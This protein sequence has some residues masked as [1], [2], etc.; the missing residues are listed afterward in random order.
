MKK[1]ALFLT[2]IILLLACRP[3]PIISVTP[4][5]TEDIPPAPTLSTDGAGVPV[6]PQYGKGTISQIAWSPDGKF[7][8][9]GG[10]AGIHL[11]TA[12]TLEEIRFIPTD[13]LITSVAFSPDGKWLASGSADQSFSRRTYWRRFSPWGSEN[14]FV[15]LWDVETGDLQATLETGLSYV[16][17]VAFSPA[18]DLLVSGSMYPDDNAVRIWKVDSVL[19]GDLALWQLHKEH[20]RG[21][22]GIAFSPD[23][24][25]L[26]TGSGDNSARLWD[27]Y[28]E[29]MESILMY[30]SAAKVKV[31]AVDYSPIV[32]DDGE[33][34]VALAGADF[35]HNTPTALLEIWDAATGE[36]VFEL[37]GH[38]SSLDSVAFSPD[39]KILASGGSYPDNKIHL[40]DVETGQHLRT[41]SGHYSGVRSLAFSPDGRIL[42]S[43]GWD[44]I[45][46]L[47]DLETGELKISNDEHSSF[48]H[49]EAISPDERILGRGGD[50]GLIRLWD[51]ASG[52][53]LG[54]LNTESSRVTNLLFST[55]GSIL[56]AS[57]DEPDFNIQLWDLNAAKRI[58]TLNGHKNFAQVLVLSPDENHLASGGALG[59]NTVYIWDLKNDGVLLH[60]IDGH[61]R[62]VKSLAFSDDGELLASG[63]GKG[64]IRLIAVLTGE[65]LHLIEA[66]DCAVS[67]LSFEQGTGN[68]IS[69]DCDD[70]SYSWDVKTGELLE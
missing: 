34:L 59:D 33:E 49:S 1:I 50:A 53:K 70:I 31:F 6:S 52:E 48:V 37:D 12:G 19:Q 26:L 9:A 21:I 44:A 55:D 46:H 24:K 29:K 3:T 64:N 13:F 60:S 36:L 58:S 15:Q 63:D 32:G 42:A 39:G 54:V 68:L 62:S 41:L 51:R 23:G 57:T 20:T 11:Y 28:G 56:I 27:V 22:F 2:L 40:W 25:R 66:H 65:V 5:E 16:T 43:S 69:S 45:L 61:T 17:T 18:G 47:W 67:S 30:K 35:F 8:V 14:N 10:S 38:D 4:S 7:I